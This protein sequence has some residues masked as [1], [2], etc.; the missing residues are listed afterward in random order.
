VRDDDTPPPGG[1]PLRTYL[2]RL[3]WLSMLPLLLLGTLLAT[4]EIRAAR[5]EQRDAATRLA[6][7]IRANVDGVLRERI[8]TLS[9]LAES[10][11]LA[12]ASRFGDF[13][14][15]AQAFRRGFGSE[16]IVADLQ[17]HMLL[18][19]GVPY[20]DPLPN[21]PRPEGHA[22]APKAVRTGQPAVG[23]LVLGP[24]TK[25]RLIA[26]AVP[27]RVGSDVRYVVLTTVEA[28]VF[29]R[30]LDEL[31]IPSGWTATL[32]DG[33]HEVIAQWPAAADAVVDA[34][35]T[36]RFDAAPALAPWSVVVTI[37]SPS[38]AEAIAPIAGALLLAVA[39]ATLVGLLAGTIG[40]RRLTAAVQ[41]LTAGAPVA[42]AGQSSILELS[43][44]RQRLRAESTER[45]A[46]VTAL[47]QSEALFRG[48]FDGLPDAL[49]LAGRDRRIIEVNP[50]FTALFGYA[51]DEVIGRTT[52][53]LYADPADY[54]ATGRARFQGPAADAPPIYELRYRRRDGA[55]FCGESALVRID[56]AD[57]STR[58]ACGIHRD[59]TARKLAEAS[60]REAGERFATI[61]RTSPVAIAIT[62]ADNYHVVEI[63]PAFEQLLG[64]RPDELVGRTTTSA[65]LWVDGALRAGVLRAMSADTLVNGLDAQMRR[66]SGEI[67]DVSFSGCRV[68]IGETLHFVAML[69]DIST[70][71]QAQRSLQHHQEELKA[72]VDARTAELAAANEALAGRASEA[73][74]ASRA[75]SA[76]LANMS[77]E[78][79]TPMNAILGLT[80][81][82]MRE[83][84][85]PRQRGRLE[86][87]DDSA[88]HLL[89]VINDILD[90]SKIEAGKMLLEDVEFPIDRVMTRAFEMV[91]ARA[92]EKGLELILDTDHLPDRLRGDATRLTQVLINLLSNAVK[93]TDKGW[94]RLRGELLQE[95]PKRLQVRFE[96][97][98]TG[99]GISPEDQRRL[100]DAFEQADSSTTRRY[101][102][103]G[104]G[105]ALT[106]HFAT[107]MQGEA[108][109]QSTAG[110]GSAFW[111]TAWLGRARAAAEDAGVVKL[112]GR[113]A[114][115]VDD[116]PEARAA[117]HDRLEAM[118]LRVDM[119]AQGPE[120]VAHAQRDFAAGGRYD[121]VLL[122]WR[123]QPLDGAQTL[124]GLR[125]A[126]GD[127]TP[128]SIL[129]TAHDDAQMWKEARAAHFDAILVK[130][131]TASALHD[132]LVQVLA[133]PA[134]QP[135]VAL[136]VTGGEMLLKA[137]HAGRR[138]LL[139]E[140]NPVNQDVARELLRAAGLHVE[141]ADDGRIAVDLAV[142]RPY[143]LVLMDMQ[144]PELDGLAATRA[145]RDL[146]GD[147][148]P[149]IA[150]TA[151]A[152][153]EDRAACL[154][155]G[156]NDHVSKPVD[157]EALYATLLRWL[158]A[159][160]AGDAPGPDAVG[161]D[162][163]G[164]DG[165]TRAAERASRPLAERLA[166]IDGLD[167]Q[168]ALR[169][170]GGQTSL[171]GRAL[172]SFVDVYREG[173]PEFLH[174]RRLEDVTRWR[175]VAHSLIGAS[176]TI[177]ATALFAHVK[178]FLD[179][180][181]A[182]GDGR[183]LAAE[184]RR[185][186]EELL[187]L[188]DRIRAELAHA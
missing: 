186:H 134:P 67:I 70:Q 79:R 117:L 120:A 118:G 57:G 38:R 73:E 177:G 53:F 157:P 116:L 11:L 132:T 19:S 144:M 80:H 33:Q 119:F 36:S 90:L 18:H 161:A 168:N 112:E 54:E 71:K 115:L 40:S 131:I 164:A 135:D 153:G 175:T 98:D 20:G 165:A 26:I 41:A 64:F 7:R 32:R 49:V 99:V 2:R 154:A 149:I 83:A 108:G 37:S 30:M 61:F 23:D 31:A 166:S 123:M 44:A 43:R 58:Y 60:V 103:T 121:V 6:A 62:R 87:I 92:R 86:K 39:G 106:R 128:P 50:A 77:H 124:A 107:M 126:L 125:A 151:N 178:A 188:V 55:T 173:A 88:R 13:H 5:S 136:D 179:A 105:L 75:K 42:G 68:N 9:V 81:L 82:M 63:N 69:V 185:L 148:M 187:A 15:N 114:L 3:V 96:V 163:G 127:A 176:G 139:A 59:I 152:F 100:F 56:D 180:I 147:A 66:K 29:Q 12:D 184:A 111:F 28:K 129:V 146:K 78:I 174:A 24:V 46:A 21:L 65:G 155:A 170:L 181:H 8:A 167:V 34:D 47:T 145:I 91:S 48:L 150:M 25:T 182:S 142:M 133:A 183:E 138:I 162:P 171:L 51:K 84:R 110:V 102:G 1:L 109:V 104:L 160:R 137:R 95:R 89:Q 169:H 122:D 93:F 156:M 52:E 97:Q 72:L 158:P 143:D 85:D 22:A 14:R 16:V 17:G 141:T 140:D 74:A 113:R 76:F 159:A 45:E 101:G 10:P 94:V 35:A 4:H 172:E 130:P 27:A